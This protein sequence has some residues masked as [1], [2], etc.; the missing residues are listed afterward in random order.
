MS[1]LDNVLFVDVGNTRIKYMVAGCTEI[2]YA[3]AFDSLP[4]QG[5]DEVRVATVSRHKEVSDWSQ[6]VN[7]PVRVARVAKYHKGLTVAYDDV[8]RLGVDRW[9]AMLA[10][11]VEEQKGFSVIDLGTAITADF[12]DNAGMHLGG[13]IMPGYRLMKEAL[14]V[15]TTQVGFGGD[16]SRLEPGDSTESCV[17][18]G[19]NRMVFSW[20]ANIYSMESKDNLFVLTGGDAE[21][22]VDTGCE[23]NA[24]IDKTLVIR[25]LRYCFE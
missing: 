21:K 12:V 1:E 5:V 7:M 24:E 18:H 3:D 9:L 11:W 6:S 13:Y 22:A 10:L 4:L 20:L 14:G 17:D 16:S 8:S 19:I 23:I 25:G 2:K 15:H